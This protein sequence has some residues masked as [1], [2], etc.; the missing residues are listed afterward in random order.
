MAAASARRFVLPVL[1]AS[2]GCSLCI[3]VHNLP[4]QETAEDIREIFDLFGSI[5]S[6]YKVTWKTYAV[7]QFFEES[8]AKNALV[9]KFPKPMQQQLAM[10]VEPLIYTTIEQC[11]DYVK[12]NPLTRE[13]MCSQLPSRVLKQS[14][15][16][17]MTE[18][19]LAVPLMSHD[20]PEGWERICPPHHGCEIYLNH[21]TR[22]AYYEHPVRI[23]L[24]Q[25]EH[26]LKRKK[27]HEEWNLGQE[28]G[29]WT[30]FNRPP[31]ETN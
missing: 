19:D 3:F 24:H 21:I 8:S 18:Y 13:K 12:K 26:Y 7:V 10:K 20:L 5:K 14:A 30:D 16:R 9:Y 28:E 22:K 11:D 2:Q 1:D 23:L 17:A 6:V 4:C 27:I 15:I 25:R 29:I 31:P